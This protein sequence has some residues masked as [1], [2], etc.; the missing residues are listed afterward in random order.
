[1]AVTTVRLDEHEKSEGKITDQLRKDLALVATT[2]ALN[3]HKEAGEKVTGQLREAL[4]VVID[5]IQIVEREASAAE[6][7]TVGL[8]SRVEHL[9]GTMVT[10]DMLDERTRVLGAQ[11]ETVKVELKGDI[12]TLAGRLE[13]ALEAIL[14]IEARQRNGH[15]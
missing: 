7:A 9:A 6:E 11:L 14:R 12:R 10:R 3:E 5:R 4:S 2:V 13:M 15:G 8:D 1:M